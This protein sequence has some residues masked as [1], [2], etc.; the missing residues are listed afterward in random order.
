MLSK[1]LPQLS[2]RTL[3][4]VVRRTLDVLIATLGLILLSPLF[5][6]LAI[7]IKLDTPGP[8][9]YHAKRIGRYG[10]PFFLYKFRTM[11]QNA[12]K[13]GPGITVAGD[14][15]VTNVGDFLRKTKLDELP[16]LINV[17]RGQMSLVGPRPE[18][19]RYVALYTSKQRHILQY[20]PGITSAAS[21]TYRREEELLTGENWEV[22][23]RQEVMPTK[24]SIDL[25]YLENRTILSDLSLVFRT[26]TAMMPITVPKLSYHTLTG[27]RMRYLMSIDLICITIALVASFV[28]RYE[29][30]V[31][32]GPYLQQNWM[33][34]F[35]A[36]FVR[37]PVYY[38]FRLYYR[39]WRYASTTDLGTILLA[40]IVSSGL[41]YFLNFI[42]FP[43]LG[44]PN[45]P[46]RS[47][48]VLEGVLSMT[49]LGGTRLLL[50][51][52]QSRVHLGNVDY[53]HAKVKN[54][55]KVLIAGAGDAGAVILR[56]MQS[57]P[58]LG[59]KP[60][61]F[62]DDD[63]SK[64][65]LSVNGVPI[66]GDRYKIPEL[67]KTYGINQIII[68]MPTAT[69][70]VIREIVSICEKAGLVPQT[71]PGIYELLDGKVGLEQLRNVEIEDLLRREPVQT[72]TRAV[73]NLLYQKR[74]LITGGGGSIGSELCRQI[75]SCRPAEIVLVGHG[76]NSIFDIYN[77]L[78]RDC[79]R[80]QLSAE[81][82]G[83]PPSYVPKI[84]AYI[85]DIR[86]AERLQ[87]IF[88]ETKP[89]IVFH[90]A[91]HKHVPLMELNP[92]EAITNNIIGTR[93]ILQAALSNQ[94][95]HF[96]MIST[97][98]AVNPTSIMGASK[99][100]AELLVLDAAQKSGKSYV[101]VRFG[102]VLGSRGSV[103]HTF[104]QQIK[105]GGP[106]TVT[107][108][109]MTRY[110]M[111]IPEAVQLVLQAGVLG[112]GGEVFLLDMGE[113]VKIVDLARD[114]I[115]LSGFDV[116]HDIDIVFSGTRPG[117]KLFEELFVT[118]EDYQ[119]T[120]HEKIF[121]ARNAS[122][123]VPDRLVEAID[124]LQFAAQK[125]DEEAI[126]RSLQNLIPEYQPPQF[127]KLNTQNN[128]N[129][130]VRPNLRTVAG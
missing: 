67:V 7:C 77:E 85:A 51:I 65:K 112:H 42:L 118:G 33:I 35:I 125:E 34:F 28:I 75:F 123:F 68:A 121:I 52:L 101:A 113:P 21:F 69:G 50:R 124:S 73:A 53:L 71:V 110:F 102:N 99:R 92:A 37:L 40:S 103:V 60:V 4:E 78:R 79:N 98:K 129:I 100:A 6:L 30:L 1:P 61:G 84:R 89:D 115:E 127:T 74:V 63:F 41:I 22:V 64:H 43:F 70:R 16:Q 96:V 94:V 17:L 104:K 59:L 105:V 29:A 66:F 36:L 26:V 120:E 88:N 38:L 90:A 106:V 8:I 97:D 18:D 87:K 108:P 91:A 27:L 126:I 20:R 14:Q 3:D 44:L 5:V 57:N 24:I 48:W 72:D 2:N 130:L 93:N 114:M 109:E 11:R 76:E 95:E 54:P 13:C 62:V 10:K 15:R 111:T 39:F 47:I 55:Q 83:L 46:S 12:D 128:H 49:L 117:E 122:L 32:V 45:C 81:E 86:F 107:D 80:M 56:E 23:Y 31:N 25:D 119:R 19:P 116:G 82:D 9:L 58:G